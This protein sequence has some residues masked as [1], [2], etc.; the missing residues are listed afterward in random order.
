MDIP[1]TGSLTDTC[2]MLEGKLSEI[3]HQLCNVQVVL[4]DTEGDVHINL[5]DAYGEFVQV[6]PE[7]KEMNSDNDMQENGENGA[8]QED[9][10]ETIQ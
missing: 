8:V 3:E 2:Q 9:D 6:D 10:C 5:P 1:T 7:E 4:Q